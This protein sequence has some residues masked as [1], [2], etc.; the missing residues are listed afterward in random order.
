MVLPSNI[1]FSCKISPSSNS[2]IVDFQGFLLQKAIR[3]QIFPLDNY[4]LSFL[5]SVTSIK[6]WLLL[7]SRRCHK[8]QLDGWLF[9]WRNSSP[10]SCPAVGL[11][12]SRNPPPMPRTWPHPHFLRPQGLRPF[13]LLKP[14]FLWGLS[15]RFSG[16]TAFFR[17]LQSLPRLLMFL[18]MKRMVKTASSFA[19]YNLSEK[20]DIRKPK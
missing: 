13:T 1:G 18:P 12:Y 5:Q 3:C 11:I 6:V 9:G 7:Y 17:V 20:L 2:M 15:T 8:I 14:V 4:V 19:V 10:T 16:V